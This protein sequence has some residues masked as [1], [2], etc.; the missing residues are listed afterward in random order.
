LQVPK[1]KGALQ[2]IASQNIA[3][4]LIKY[5]DTRYVANPIEVGEVFTRPKTV[6]ARARAKRALAISDKYNARQAEIALT[7]TMP[8]K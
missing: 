5:Y 8:V 1:T 4:P 7:A 6:D 3:A 2:A